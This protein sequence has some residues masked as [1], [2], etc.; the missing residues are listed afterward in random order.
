[1]GAEVEVSLPKEKCS[2]VGL[3]HT[4]PSSITHRGS[5]TPTLSPKLA[6]PFPGSS[7]QGAIAPCLPRSVP[8]Q[9][10]LQ[11]GT[12]AGQPGLI[13]KANGLK[14]VTGYRRLFV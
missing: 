2:S 1:M 3:D 12:T 10:Q 8:E 9:R 4:F 11:R 5:K 7:V 13:S 14:N 6:R